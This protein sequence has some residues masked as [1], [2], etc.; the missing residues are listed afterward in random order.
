MLIFPYTVQWYNF[1]N[2]SWNQCPIIP[3]KRELNWR[4]FR[5]LHHRIWFH[6]KKSWF[7]SVEKQEI[8][9]FHDFSFK[10]K[11]ER[12]VLWFIDFD[13]TKKIDKMYF[14]EELFSFFFLF[15]KCELICISFRFGLPGTYSRPLLVFWFW[16]TWLTST[17]FW[18]S[19]DEWKMIW[20]IS[21]PWALKLNW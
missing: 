5:K 12:K 16:Q 10:Y 7:C 4:N 9:W 17:C 14:W 2:I 6:E 1:C 19:W 3:K 20:R 21:K 8:M 13:L 18:K 11:F 15:S